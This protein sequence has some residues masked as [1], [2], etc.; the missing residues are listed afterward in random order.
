MADKLEEL[1]LAYDKATAECESL[2]KEYNSKLAA[3]RK[4]RADYERELYKNESCSTCKYNVITDFSLE[5]DHNLCGCDDAP[6]TCCHDWCENYQPDTPLTKAIKDTLDCFIDFTAYE[7][8]K[9]FYGDILTATGSI[10]PT[11]KDYNPTAK[12][13][14]NILKATEH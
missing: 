5:G 4:A 14:Y 13:L 7:G 12:I 1:K 11:D 6:C 3:K 9:K 2:C 8:L 10:N